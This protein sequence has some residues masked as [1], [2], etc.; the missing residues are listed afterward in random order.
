LKIILLRGNLALRIEIN[1]RL[2]CELRI[3]NR[4]TII[5]GCVN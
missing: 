2:N 5:V 4:E 3:K 1:G